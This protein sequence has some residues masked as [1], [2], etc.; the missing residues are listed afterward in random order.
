MASPQFRVLPTAYEQAARDKQR[1]QWDRNLLVALFVL[2]GMTIFFLF[3]LM[4]IAQSFYFSLY[5]W[6][7]FGP[8]TDYVQFGN[9]SRLLNHSVFQ[10]AVAHSFTIMTLSLLIQLPLALGLALLVGRGKLRGRRTF[11]AILFIPYV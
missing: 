5:N 6:E 11:R 7:G 9:Y 10:L 8:P 1:R 2:P 3:V 4:P